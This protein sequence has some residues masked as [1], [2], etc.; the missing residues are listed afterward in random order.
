MNRKNFLKWSSTGLFA[1]AF[2]L[3]VAGK[4]SGR[5]ANNGWTDEEN[6]FCNK[7][8]I[9]QKGMVCTSQP[10]A[11]SAGYDV[12]RN[13][14][15]AIDAAIAANAML[16]LTEPMMCGLG[17]DLFAIVWSEREKKLFGLN[18]SGRSPYN[19][20]IAEAKKMGLKSIPAFGPLSWSVPGCVSGWNELLKKFGSKSLSELLQ[21]AIHYAKEGFPVTTN[22]SLDWKPENGVT[23]YATLNGTFLFGNRGPKAGEIFHNLDFARTLEILSKDGAT[24]FY[25]GEIANRIIK[26]SKRHGG[27]FEQKDFTDHAVNW[28]D[29]LSTNYRGYDV[30]ELPP[31]GQGMVVLQMLNILERFDIARLKPNSAEHFHLFLEAKKLSFQDRAVYYADMDFAKVPIEQLISKNYAIERAKL[32][33]PRKAMQSMQPGRIRNSSNTIYITT[34][35]DAGNMVSLIQS[36][37]SPW[38]SHYVVDNLGFAL[39]NRG[40]LFSLNDAAWNK[41]E[42]HKR[43]LHTIIPAF[44]TQNDKPIF[45][46]GVT[47]GDF[48]PQG[49]VQILTNIIDHRMPIQKAGE[50]FRLWHRESFEFTNEK[51]RDSGKIVAE[52]GFSNEVKRQLVQMGHQF[53]DQLRYFGGYQGIWRKSEP[54]IYAGA[55]DC[56]KDGCAFGY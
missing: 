51:A 43:P 49:Q 35:D 42:P 5:N 18:A 38:G 12:L 27:R 1:T 52:P 7:E 2:R 8:I 36:L 21:P 17:G 44:V 22:I 19:W 47:G 41:L 20:S 32:I 25:E 4:G 39:Q 56:R 46:F 23:D 37:Y 48:Q 15:N 29:P 45:S 11:V 3:E 34:A 31:N 13:G 10:L 6:Y 30:W 53:S 28:I 26:F 14:G 54:R 9:G 16:S 33:D 50:Q 40:A 55:S 24:S